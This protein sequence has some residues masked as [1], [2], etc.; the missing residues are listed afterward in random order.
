MGEFFSLLQNDGEYSSA[1]NWEH[2]LSQSLV[3]GN[4]VEP[5]VNRLRVHAVS[6]TV[7]D[8]PGSVI[9][10]GDNRPCMCA[11]CGKGCSHAGNLRVHNMIHTGEK[12]HLCQLC[13]KR[14][15]T[16][17]ELKRHGL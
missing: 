4:K 1:S 6:G 15:V 11:V 7:S 10:N 12:P 2:Y 9:H 13:G 8:N 3:R 14:F 16:S 17:S 5:G